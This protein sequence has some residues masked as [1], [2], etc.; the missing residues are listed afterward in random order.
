MTLLKRIVFI[1][2][3]IFCNGIRA[4]YY[5]APEF[6]R[7]VEKGTRTF[8]GIPG[9][10]YFQN[11]SDYLIEA[12]FNPKN[13]RLD[14]RAR[15]IYYN[16]SPDTLRRLVFRLYHNFLKKGGIRDQSL[17]EENIQD[18]VSIKKLIV[19]G[20]DLTERMNR[21]LRYRATNMYMN[22]PDP[23]IPFTSVTIKL[24]WR[25]TLPPGDVHR[26]GKYGNN[27]Y[28]IGYWY[29]QLAVYDDIDGWDE[30]IYNVTQEFYNDFNRYDVKINV[31]ADYMVW[32]TGLWL[33]PEEI[34]SKQTF[35]KYQLAYQSD[36][37]IHIIDPS[38]RKNKSWAVNGKAK[39]FHY[40]I[41]SI[42]D[43]AFAVSDKYLWDARSVVVDSLS[44]RRVLVSA[45]YPQEAKHFD[46]VADI[47]ARAIHHFSFH[48]YRVPYPYP[49]ATVFK[50]EGGMEYPMM[51]NDGETFF[52]DR[53]VFVTMHE[54]AH[55][56]YP[57]LT[58]INER[59]YAWIDEGLTTWL[60]V[61]T[62]ASLNSSTYTLNDLVDYYDRVAGL[63][64]DVPFGIPS[65]Y[66]RDYAYYVHAYARSSVAFHMLEEYM[67][68]DTFRLALS[69]FIDTWKHKHPT[70]YDLFAVLQA[71][72][73][74]ELGWYVDQWFYMQGFP[75][76]A[77]A[78][79]SMERDTI[80]MEIKK[81]GKFAVPVHIKLEYRDAPSQF[82]RYEP[83]IWR[84]DD[85]LTIVHPLKGKLKR[86]ML[87]QDIIPDRNRSD[88]FR[89]F[90]VD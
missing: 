80:R 65:Y 48:S 88:N 15:I 19:N 50:G 46:K 26:F 24:E 57:F 39:S 3:V 2:F 7:A 89:E 87:N 34:L 28:F 1:G 29:P 69:H 84:S 17:N 85:L 13:G 90:P 27:N 79:A 64:E 31:P 77:I 42:P 12:D 18:G 43:F 33:N 71:N 38:D 22:L 37:T 81:K 32:A 47:G 72:T 45:A 4:Q 58:G 51:V 68:R 49:G 73:S 52:Y 23:L 61:E 62:E 75:D 20:S 74:K 78:E 44:G 16:T 76:L 25:T 53:T 56:Y 66:T 6:S 86:I 21:L 8:T 41:D 40:R 83:D 5:I 55:A 35:S 70:P 59:K 60:P 36:S 11:H 10:E 30:L 82:I 14:G 67:G 54:L 9:D 63:E